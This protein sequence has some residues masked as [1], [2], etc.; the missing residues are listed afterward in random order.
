MEEE[1]RWY[2]TSVNVYEFFGFFCWSF[3]CVYNKK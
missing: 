2:I 1:H 3:A